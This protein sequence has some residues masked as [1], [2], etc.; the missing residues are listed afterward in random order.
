MANV[1]SSSC[2]FVGADNVVRAYC[3]RGVPSWAI[4]HNKQFMFKC[5]CTDISE[6][7]QML[8]EHL[9]ALRNSVATYTLCVYEDIKPGM[10]IK[11]RTENDGSFNFQLTPKMDG[12]NDIGL[13]REIRQAQIEQDM[14]LAALEGDEGEE[15]VSGIG[16]LIGTI[17]EVMTIP[18]IADIVGSFLNKLNNKPAA[19]IGFAPDN[20]NV[21]E[22][23]FQNNYSQ[24]MPAV[25]ITEN[26]AERL[27]AAYAALKTKM[28][29]IL[30]L[31]EQ[32]AAMSVNNPGKF[33]TIKA[34]I[35]TFVN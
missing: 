16:K 7:E 8:A 25:E 24:D 22:P 23:N 6:G 14:R 21:M 2:Q 31:L 35:K 1:S 33:D 20:N 19:A 11:S 9:E 32:L 26:E 3:R 29:E 5:E 27:G 18:G 34:M 12:G 17:K 4:W 13:L 30:P 15:E 10:K 28:P